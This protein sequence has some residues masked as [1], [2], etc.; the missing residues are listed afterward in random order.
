VR[1]Q[2]LFEGSDEGMPPQEEA[3]ISCLERIFIL[4]S[5]GE[6]TRGFYYMLRESPFF[7]SMNRYDNNNN[8]NTSI[9]VLIYNNN[10]NNSIQ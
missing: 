5:F 1:N 7:L 10:N 2:P 3:T 6:W 9:Q 4:S 8:D